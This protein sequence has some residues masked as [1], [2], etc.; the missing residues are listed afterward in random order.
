MPATISTGSETA[1]APAATIRASVA[2]SASVS[3]A[4]W[5]LP[6]A[7]LPGSTTPPR[8]WTYSHSSSTWPERP[9][10]PPGSENCATF[11]CAPGYPMKVEVYSFC[12]TWR[13]RSSSPTA[14]V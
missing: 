1:T 13:W 12:C 2:S 11:R 9:G 7:L 6:T 4:M 8:G 10:C 3:K 14:S 5:P